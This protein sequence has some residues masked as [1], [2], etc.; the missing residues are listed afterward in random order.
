MLTKLEKEARKYGILTNIIIRKVVLEAY[1]QQ[2]ICSFIEVLKRFLQENE[3][4]DGLITLE[5]HPNWDDY[6]VELVISVTKDKKEDE[7]KKEIKQYKIKERRQK[8][9]IIDEKRKIY[10]KLKAEFKRGIIK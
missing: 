6:E 5:V 1:N 3:V 2:S 7:I 9:K 8:Q 4:S 10:E